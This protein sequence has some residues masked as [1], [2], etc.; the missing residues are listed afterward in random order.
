MIERIFIRLCPKC[1]SNTKGEDVP[2][3][4]ACLRPLKVVLVVVLSED[5]E[6]IE[7]Q[8]YEVEI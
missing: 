2:V 1:P 5:S 4:C 8:V 6:Q 3:V 7:E